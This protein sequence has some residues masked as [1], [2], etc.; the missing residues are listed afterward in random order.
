MKKSLFVCVQ[1]VSWS[2][3]GEYQAGN[4][5]LLL[6]NLVNGESGILARSSSSISSAD[7]GNPSGIGQPVS[8]PSAPFNGFAAL[9]SLPFLL[10]MA[11]MPCKHPISDFTP[12]AWR[13]SFS[14]SC[15]GESF[16]T[17]RR[18]GNWIKT[19]SRLNLFS[20]YQLNLSLVSRR[21]SSKS[22]PDSGKK[23]IIKHEITEKLAAKLID[24]P[25]KLTSRSLSSKY[26]FQQLY[27]SS[28][29]NVEQ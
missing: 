13:I 26:A 24:D 2:G 1:S 11:A 17:H 3:A 15:F 23:K 5:P 29:S 9:F 27:E 18:I 25:Q 19:I 6:S 14:T 8:L 10:C 4:V 28:P 21:L 7:L 16:W 20:S 12:P 22:T